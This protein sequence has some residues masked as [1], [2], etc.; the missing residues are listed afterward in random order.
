MAD[1]LL[2]E[3]VGGQ[4]EHVREIV[5]ETPTPAVA[6]ETVFCASRYRRIYA[7]D[8]QSGSPRWTFETAWVRIFGQEAAGTE[9][10]GTFVRFWGRQ[11]PLPDVGVVRRLAEHPLTPSP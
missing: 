8:L 5:E 2:P 3:S 7:V 6:E 1:F 10:A 11:R 4:L 9:T